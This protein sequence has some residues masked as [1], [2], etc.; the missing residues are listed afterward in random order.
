MCDCG[1]SDGVN[2]VVDGKPAML[3]GPVPDCSH[4][5]GATCKCR[6]TACQCACG[7]PRKTYAGDIWIVEAGHPRKE[8][9][10]AQRFAT[11][12]ASLPSVDEL[13]QEERYKRLIVPPEQVVAETR[14]AELVGAKRRR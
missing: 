4:E 14:K 5:A 9:M 10:L 12:D 2:G 7:I 3:P 11:G 8:M 6:D 13:M 1:C